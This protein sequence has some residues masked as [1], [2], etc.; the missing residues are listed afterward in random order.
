MAAKKRE[1]FEGENFHEF[2][3]FVANLE[4][5]LKYG[6]VASFGSTTKQSAKIFS[7]RIFFTNLRRFS[8]AKVSHYSVSNFTHYMQNC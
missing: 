3:G 2:R 6:G 7:M 5:F 4:S 1:T 8:P